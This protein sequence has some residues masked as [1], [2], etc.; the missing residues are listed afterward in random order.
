MLMVLYWEDWENLIEVLQRSFSPRT[1]A[2]GLG[3][4]GSS[5][6]MSSSSSIAVPDPHPARWTGWMSGLLFGT[7]R[8]PLL[9]T[10]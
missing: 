2:S 8:L 9:R 5:K 1:C 10:Q 7:G 6:V 4:L 3:F